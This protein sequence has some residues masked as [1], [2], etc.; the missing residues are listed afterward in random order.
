MTQIK[1]AVNMPRSLSCSGRAR[2]GLN[3]DHFNLSLEDTTQTQTS[4]DGAFR[5]LIQLSKEHQQ[6]LTELEET[7]EELAVTNSTAQKLEAHL[8]DLD[9]VHQATIEVLEVAGN[10]LKDGSTAKVSSLESQV[11]KLSQELREAHEDL[12]YLIE[13]H[14]QARSDSSQSD[15]AL[16]EYEKTLG[17]L[18]SSKSAFLQSKLDELSEEHQQTLEEL[19]GARQDPVDLN[20]GYQQAVGETYSRNISSP[21]TIS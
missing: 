3:S 7:R 13:E 17:E 5:K 10:D 6:I 4:G 8:E 20:G 12:N 2:L 14:K 1:S 15:A 9:E 16:T 18:V 11:D 19:K 21:N